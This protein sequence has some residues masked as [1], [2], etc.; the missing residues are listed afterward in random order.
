M[1]KFRFF[2][3][4]N[5][6]KHFF[7]NVWLSRISTLAITL[8]V[9]IMTYI[10]YTSFHDITKIYYIASTISQSLAGLYGLIL[11]GYIFFSTKVEKYIDRLSSTEEED[12]YI[13]T[14]LRGGYFR[15]VLLTGISYC[16]VFILSIMSM[17]NESPSD[18]FSLVTLLSFALLLWFSLYTLFSI[19]GLIRD[20]I[21]PTNVSKLV[22]KGDELVDINTIEKL[23]EEMADY[24]ID[25]A[26]HIS[27]DLEKEYI[28]HASDRF[29]ES[30]NRLVVNKIVSSE[31]L[32][33]A[34]H[35]Y[36]FNKRLHM[37]T[38]LKGR[39]IVYNFEV[40]MAMLEKAKESYDQKNNSTAKQ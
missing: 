34:W 28:A 35:N 11:A 19:I 13:A 26:N 7:H 17:I 5:E 36:N 16:I 2:S 10:A 12:R 20:L 8:I 32:D 24:V 23:T 30:L 39:F 4:I 18:T 22:D 14:R 15:K 25:F 9:L 40:I 6:I 31:I 3:K 38:N 27:T 21:D 33:K 37:Q 29:Y 1:T